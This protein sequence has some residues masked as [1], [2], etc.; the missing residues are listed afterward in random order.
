[1]KFLDV[2]IC[3]TNL[4]V[5][6]HDATV[7]SLL[8]FCRRLYMFRVLTP[9]ISSSYNCNYSFWHWSTRCTTVNFGC[10][11]GRQHQERMVV[12]SGWPVT[13]A[14]I[15]VV[16]DPDDGCQHPKHV[17]L[18]TGIYNKLNTVASFW[19]II[20]FDSRCTD[21]WIF[22]YLPVS[23]QSV[24]GHSAVVFDGHYYWHVGNTSSDV[25][26]ILSSITLIGYGS[27]F[28]RFSRSHTTTRHIR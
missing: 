13:E 9:I 10:W 20:K 21:P 25:S 1:M 26:P 6:Q 2:I 4:I 24:R 28:M 17:E 18:P 11:D 8:Y 12:T 19:T 16:W 22:F 7:F 27:S 23:L 3:Y 14:V 15:T 5:V